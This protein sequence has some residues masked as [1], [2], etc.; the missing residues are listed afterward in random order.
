MATLSGN[1]TLQV[2]GILPNGVPSGETFLAT[3]QAIANLGGGVTG[4]IMATGQAIIAV[5]G[6]AVQLASNVL[7]NG[8]IITAHG[9]NAASVTLGPSAALTNT[10]SGSGNG[11]ELQAGAS[12]SFAVP[13]TNN[14]WINGTAGDWV[15]FGGS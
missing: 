1:E 4:A 3:T 15:S 13:N 7:I 14:I 10:L 11:Q 8:V 2:Q 6:T 12:T 5:T 9:T